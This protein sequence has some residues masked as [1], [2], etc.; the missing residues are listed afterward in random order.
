MN[1]AASADAAKEAETMNEKRVA[2]VTGG[3]RGIGAAIVQAAREGRLARRRRRP[4]RWTSSRRSCDE[5]KAAGGSAEPM[6]CD[7]ADSK[8]ARRS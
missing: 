6:A 1:G 8:R 5:I 2:I 7:I 4:Q 3:S